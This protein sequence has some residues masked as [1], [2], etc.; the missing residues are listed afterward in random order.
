MYGLHENEKLELQV[1]NNRSYIIFLT[2]QCF[3]QAL[4]FLLILVTGDLPPLSSLPSRFFIA[5]LLLVLSS[6]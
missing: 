1:F 2:F 5:R 6:E 3:E 4:S